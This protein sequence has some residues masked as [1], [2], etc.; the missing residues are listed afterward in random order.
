MSQCGEI[1]FPAMEHQP[2]QK[3]TVQCQSKRQARQYYQIA[4]WLRRQRL[5][6]TVQMPEY[7]LQELLTLPFHLSSHCSTETDP[8]SRRHKSSLSSA[9]PLRL[10]VLVAL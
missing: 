1:A 10:H 9:L 4:F 2:L 3:T 6:K 7:T 5:A 8:T